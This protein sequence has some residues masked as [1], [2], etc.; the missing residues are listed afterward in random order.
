MGSKAVLHESGNP[1]HRKARSAGDDSRSVEAGHVGSFVQRRHGLHELP[2]NGT[3][4]EQ[5]SILAR[6]RLNFKI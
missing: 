6:P 3:E 2:S 1:Y 4:A 5:A